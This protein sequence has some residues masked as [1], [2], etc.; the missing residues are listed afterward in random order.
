MKRAIWI[1]G[2]VAGL[3]A[4][5]GIAPASAGPAA[6]ARADAAEPVTHRTVLATRGTEEWSTLMRLTLDARGAVIAS[7]DATPDGDKFDQAT[8]VGGAMWLNVTHPNPDQS[9]PRIVVRRPNAEPLVVPGMDAV[10]TPG[11]TAI[12][13][14]RRSPPFGPQTHDELVMYY[15]ADGHIRSLVTLPDG[16]VTTDLRYSSDGTSLWMFTGRTERGTVGLQE[17]RFADR[18]IVRTIPL[19]GDSGCRDL[20]LLPSGQRMVLTCPAQTHSELWVVQLSTGEVLHKVA[21]PTGTN[22]DVIHGRLSAGVLLVSASA[23]SPDGGEP[24][25]WLGALDLTTF[26]VRRLTGSTGFHSAVVAY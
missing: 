21:L 3:V 2:L 6:P 5:L 4:G 7:E 26:T 24:A 19:N 10:F 11:R 9:D 25:R 8:D 1:A 23:D 15:L 14:V 16:H 22:V 18:R 20:E 13:V 17:F 12:V